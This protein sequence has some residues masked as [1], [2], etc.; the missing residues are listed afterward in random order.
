MFET[1]GLEYFASGKFMKN[2][3]PGP[4]TDVSCLDKSCGV[5]LTNNNITSLYKH[6]FNTLYPSMAFVGI[7]LTALPFLYYDLQV[8]WIFSVWT[9]MRSLPSTDK[10]LSSIDE[11]YLTC[12]VDRQPISQYIHLLSSRQ[13]DYFNELAKLGASQTMDDV[14][15]K[16][17][18]AVYQ[19]KVE[20][21]S[22][23]KK[24]QISVTGHSS[25]LQP[26]EN[27]SEY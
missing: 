19:Y 1:D 6:V 14:V 11:D 3:L 22:G 12:L 7:N 20:D 25:F 24:Y 10:M 16:L 8:R 13:W 18:D 5:S 2:I 26:T 27:N 17:Y 23:Y 21:P 4:L 15:K 9:G